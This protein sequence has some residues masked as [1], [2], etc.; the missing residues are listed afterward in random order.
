[1]GTATFE[2]MFTFTSTLSP[3]KHVPHGLQ[4]KPLNLFHLQNVSTQ[5]HNPFRGCE[6]LCLIPSNFLLDPIL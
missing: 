1:M 5:F 3:W 2:D 4:I 6:A